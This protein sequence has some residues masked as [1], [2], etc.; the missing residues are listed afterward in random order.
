MKT[1]CWARKAPLL[2]AAVAVAALVLTVPQ[3]WARHPRWPTVT[4]PGHRPMRWYRH[5]RLVTRPVEARADRIILRLR[6][7]W[8]AK[9]LREQPQVNQLFGHRLARLWRN[10]GM[11]SIT[12]DPD[13]LFQTLDELRRLPMVESAELDYLVYPAYVPNTPDYRK[14][15][16]H[17]LLHTPEAWDVKAPGE[18]RE[19]VIAFVDTGADLDHPDLTGRFWINADEVPNNGL[20]DDANGF[21]DDVYGWDFYNDN[22]DPSPEPDGLDNNFDGDPDEQVS[23]GTLGAGL[24]GAKVYD[25]WGTAGVYPNARIMPIQVF[26]DDGGTDYQTVVD[27]IEYAVDN[28]AEVINLSIGAP[29]STVF[30]TP[31]V[32]AYNR[33]M[34]VVAA[35]GNYN[36]ELTDT[37]WWSPV[38]NEGA[39]PLTDNKVIGVAYTDKYD[40]KGSYSN[41]DGSSGRHF[42]DLCAPGDAIY[43]P[44]YQ[45]PDFP[46]FTKY[47]YTNTG[48]SFAAPM[49]SGL[50]A[51]IKALHPSWG[52]AQIRDQITSTADNIDRFNP[53]YAGKLGA[54]RI[55]CAR[56]H[57]VPLGPAPPTNVQAYDTP[58]DQGG[59]VTVTWDLSADDGAG[60]D[61]VTGYEI[62]RRLGST[63]SFTKVADVAAGTDHWVDT[64][65]ENGQE[66]YYKVGASN[67]TDVTYSD[68]VGPAVPA[69]NLPPPPITTLTAQDVPGDQGGSIELDWGDYSPPTDCVGY[70]IYRD[71]FPF[72]SVGGRQPIAEINDPQ[73]Q[74]YLDPA[75]VDYTDYYYAVTAIDAADNEDP[76]VQTAGPVQSYPN[77]T[78]HLSAGTYLLSPPVVPLDGDPATLFG[79]EANF[80]T[81]AWDRT[82]Q[83]YAIYHPGDTLTDLLRLSLGHGVWLWTPEDLDFALDG[84]TASSG[85]LSVAVEPGWQLLG[86]PYFAAMDYSATQVQVGSTVM[87]I[88]AAAQ[89]GYVSAA[90]YTFDSSDYSYKLL[91]P[92]WTDSAWVGPW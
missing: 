8:L 35:A 70:R 25:D 83:Q 33:G 57:G 27:G 10:L 4:V 32:R 24:A 21:V 16:H 42:V 68:P 56:A 29:W 86:N 13:R 79:A 36:E 49:V 80:R 28:G 66:Y 1:N 90:A 37:Y 19:C 78:M 45:D 55:N 92:S 87:S 88:L 34:V 31:I 48:T 72:D 20:D 62:L 14:Q 91:S 17:P 58:G 84:Q 63:G 39:H 46:A 60:S 38:C 43:G 2:G 53:G 59:S 85:D 44:A 89:D 61:T 23:H 65:V 26:P 64:D 41:Y 67:G 75:T 82:S 3:A 77:T 6:T 12:V 81:A 7:D 51:L 71:Q 73:I 47:F 50:A 76:N 52:P 69:D 22:N 54:G 9:L 15:Y 30:T 40:R 11:V 5:G 18:W 74:E